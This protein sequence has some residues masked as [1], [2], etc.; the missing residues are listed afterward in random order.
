MRTLLA[1]A[2]LAAAALPASAATYTID[3]AHSLV[4]FRVRHLVSKTNGRFTA[5][6]GTIN[7]VEGKPE[8][9]SVQASI[10]PASINTDNEKR[11]GHLKS[12]DF[13]DVAK[14][15][16]MSFK[17]T[18]VAKVLESYTLTGDLTMHCVTKPVTLALEVG[19][20]EGPKAGFSAKGKLNRKDFGIV[21]NRVLDKGAAMLGE[22]VEISLDIEA[23]EAKAEAPAKEGKKK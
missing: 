14:C 9:W 1:A 6:K 23:D 15:P 16:E 13:F 12:P 5:F 10:D 8:A 19:G 22:D 7:Y 21:W 4:G 11:D 17:S 18:K 20:V 2:V 3:G